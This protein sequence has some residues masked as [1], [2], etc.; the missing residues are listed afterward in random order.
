MAADI[1]PTV[2]GLRPSIVGQCVEVLLGQKVHPHFPAYLHLR[3]VAGRSGSLAALAPDW[4]EVSRQLAVPGGPA[5]RPHLRPFWDRRRKA[6]QEWLGRNLAGSYSPASI[7]EVLMTAV[8]VDQDKR[9]T[10]RDRHWEMVLKHVLYGE[11][12]PVL[13]LAAFYLR[14]YAFRSGR[15]PVPSDLLPIFRAQF[16]YA[17][18]QDDTEFESLYDSSNPLATSVWFEKLKVME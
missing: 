14:N 10:L 13:A 6:N 11:R 2:Y 1:T 17:S 5:G 3:Q 9:Y 15:E 16:G 12:L 8:D 7:R 4:T 18:P